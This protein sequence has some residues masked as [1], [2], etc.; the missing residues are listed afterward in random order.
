MR[1][2]I[3]AAVAAGALLAPVGFFVGQG[4]RPSENEA[5]ARVSAA[6]AVRAR[7]ASV[8]QRAAVRH[9]RRHDR[10][11][12]R[13]TVRKIRRAYQQKVS[14]AFSSGQSQGFNN[15]QSVGREQGYNNGHSDGLI[16][17]SDS[18]TCSDDPDVTWLPYC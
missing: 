7:Q 1:R 5:R 13:R 8:E 10:T 3:A 16:D 14:R 17:G 2:M 12:L 18:L 11:V 6:V 9:Q 15:G 4:G